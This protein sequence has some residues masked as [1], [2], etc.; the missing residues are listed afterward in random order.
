MNIILAGPPVLAI[1][2]ETIEWEDFDGLL[3]YHQICRHSP[4]REHSTN[5]QL[6]VFSYVYK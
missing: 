1:L 4:L 5:S 2:L 3:T 6:T